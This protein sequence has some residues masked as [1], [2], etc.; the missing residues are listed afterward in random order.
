MS[1][2]KK[3]REPKI[4]IRKTGPPV[5]IWEGG[6]EAECKRLKWG[7]PVSALNMG[8]IPFIPGRA[9]LANAHRNIQIALPLSGPILRNK[10]P[11]GTPWRKR[12]IA[13]TVGGGPRWEPRA[14]GPRPK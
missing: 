1:D 11:S 7:L 4:L 5:T 3:T 6:D 9:P 8:A 14:R 12:Y 10:S 2:T 13:R